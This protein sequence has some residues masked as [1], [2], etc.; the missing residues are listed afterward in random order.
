MKTEGNIMVCV[1]QQKT[2]ERLIGSG[3]KLKESIGSDIYV[4]HVVKNNDNFL[5]NESEPD[6]LQY[7]F[8]ISKDAGADLTVL[9]SENVVETLIN[10]ANEKNIGYVVLGE[11]PKTSNTFVIDN[12]KKSLVNAEFHIIPVI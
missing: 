6:A 5:C 1:T 11:P 7:L 2:C 12:L 10:F 8:N 3:A 4:I 9:R